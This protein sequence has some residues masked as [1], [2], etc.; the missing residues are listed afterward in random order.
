MSFIRVLTI[1]FGEVFLHN[2]LGIIHSLSPNYRICEVLG[3]GAFGAVYRGVWYHTGTDSDQRISDEVAVKTI[4]QGAGEE[5][6]IILLQEAAIMGQFDHPNII[7]LLGVILDSKL[8]VSIA[9]SSLF[10]HRIYRY[11]ISSTYLI[12]SMLTN[13][14]YS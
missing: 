13:M 2:Y 8:E 14:P 5:E 4:N 3:S 7:R 11:R 1:K 12:F 6:R 9:R 10:M